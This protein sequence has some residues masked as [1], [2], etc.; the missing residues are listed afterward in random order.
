MSKVLRHGREQVTIDEE[1]V[2]V[3]RV[4]CPECGTPMTHHADK[5]V[6]AA[7]REG[8]VVVAAARACSGCGAQQSTMSAT[9]ASEMP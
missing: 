2:E 8:D 1:A 3:P 4:P 9:P 7:A 5:V 6:P